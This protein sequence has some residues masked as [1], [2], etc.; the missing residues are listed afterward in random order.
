MYVI[1]L[2]STMPFVKLFKHFVDKTF[3][4]IKELDHYTTSRRTPLRRH[5]SYSHSHRRPS[6]FYDERSN[7]LESP[8][9]YSN[10]V[11]VDPR[12]RIPSTFS[13]Y[14]AFDPYLPQATPKVASV[15]KKEPKPSKTTFCCFLFFFIV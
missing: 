11:Y 13:E 1:I 2:I 12:E 5:H 6:P 8:Y 10:P 3:L 9:S 15:K 4:L 14:S 7:I